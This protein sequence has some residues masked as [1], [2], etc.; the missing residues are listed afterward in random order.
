MDMVR[1]AMEAGLTKP[2]LIS[3]WIKERYGVYMAPGHC[4]SYKCKITGAAPRK[5]RTTPEERKAPAPQA[6]S[7]IDQTLTLADG[8]RSY[9]LRLPPELVNDLTVHL[10]PLLHQTARTPT[11]VVDKV[12]AW[13]LGDYNP[14]I[15]GD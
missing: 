11:E 13:F 12:T 4:S 1:A 9:L 6:P 8:I 5:P 7:S 15:G 10:A 2:R 3:P 14:R